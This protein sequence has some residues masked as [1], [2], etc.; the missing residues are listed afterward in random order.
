M[1]IILRCVSLQAVLDR[2]DE[3]FE[4]PLPGTPER[5]R[6]LQ[7]FMDR[8]LKREGEGTKKGEEGLK[9]KID[10]EID[11]KFMQ[12]MAEKTEGFSGRQLAKVGVEL[13]IWYFRMVDLLHVAMVVYL[14]A[15]GVI[16]ARERGSG[17]NKHIRCKGHCSTSAPGYCFSCRCD[18]CS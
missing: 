2:I 4:F 10:E 7:Q 1:K 11:E 17:E 5:L 13:F 8:Y 16:E 3:Q 12:D 15:H 6:M 9:I 14:S 18:C